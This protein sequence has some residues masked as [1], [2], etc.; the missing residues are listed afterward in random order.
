MR[1]SREE[2]LRIV[3]FYWPIFSKLFSIVLFVFLL[4]ASRELGRIGQ[5]TKK[6]LEDYPIR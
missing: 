5:R 3:S 2:K 4:A 1:K 6:R